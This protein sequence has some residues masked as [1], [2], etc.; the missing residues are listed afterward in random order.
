VNYKPPSGNRIAVVL[1]MH[2]SGT[3]LLMNFLAC[4]GV[5]AGTDLMAPSAWNALGYWEHNRIF[6]VHEKIFTLVN[7]QWGSPRVCMPLPDLWW[8]RPKI[9]ACKSKLVEIVQRERGRAK[10]LWGFKDPRTAV[11]YPLWLEIFQELDLDP[12]FFLTVR[13]PYA[14][15]RSLG[16]RD[17]LSFSTAQILWLKTYIDAVI[18]AQGKPGAIIDYDR[19]FTH[20]DEQAAAVSRALSPMVEP[21]EAEVQQALDVTVR[22]RLRHYLP[23][24]SERCSPLVL[25]YYHLL[26]Q[27]AVEGERP[28]ELPR[29]TDDLRHSY[30]L[31]GEWADYATS[32]ENIAARLLDKQAELERLIYGPLWK[33]IGAR[34]RKALSPR[35]PC[36]YP[37]CA[38]D[39]LLSVPATGARGLS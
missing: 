30:E 12:V 27:W 4:L 17:N 10:R 29:M 7:R 21:T 34:I 1:G 37:A 2:R 15:G 38:E 39:E 35:G 14:V 6:A 3:S 9:Q 26:L 24:S 36:L 22:H 31:L 19:W 5:D 32:R 23:D 33:I 20:A 16:A 13:H 28:A 8:K 25:R 11:L 18:M